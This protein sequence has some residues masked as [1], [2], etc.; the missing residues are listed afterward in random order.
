MRARDMKEV[1]ISI[2]PGQVCLS[3]VRLVNTEPELK[4]K[5]FGS[6]SGKTKGQD[7]FL[8]PGLKEK[9]LET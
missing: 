1:P 3:K 8:L 9:S 7:K 2:F 4:S 5:R 6:T